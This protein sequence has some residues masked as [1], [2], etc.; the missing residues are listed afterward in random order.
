M[1]T[2]DAK[3]NEQFRGDPDAMAEAVAS[4][5]PFP[6]G[7]PGARPRLRVLDGTGKL[8]NGVSAAIVLGAAGAQIDVV[9][10]ARSF[11]QATTQFVYYDDAYAADAAEVARRARR[12]RGGPQR[13]RPT[14]PR[15]SPSCSA[16]DYVAVAGT[17]PSAVR[18]RPSTLGGQG[19]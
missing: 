12:G 17:D 1:T 6:E 14:R 15:T 8:D 16:E 7:A 19:G 5:I 4:I 11:G 9:G 13:R 3:G 10:N 2:P 18:P